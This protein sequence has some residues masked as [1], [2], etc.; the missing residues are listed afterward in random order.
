M[1]EKEMNKAISEEIFETYLKQKMF[2][3]EGDGGLTNLN[4][5]TKDLGYRSSGFLYG[6][7]LECF[8]SDNPGAQQ[9]I[10]DWMRENISKEQS[11]ELCNELVTDEDEEETERRDEK[12][13]L[14]PVT[15]DIA[16]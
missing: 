13:G 1:N 8:L 4:T 12:N 6:S 2:H 11:D 14:Y 9:A 5:L 7:S 15:E 3:F 16:N 10:V